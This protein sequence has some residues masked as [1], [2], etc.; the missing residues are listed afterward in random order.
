MK[1]YSP[2]VLLSLFFFSN[3]SLVCSQEPTPEN[4][5]PSTFAP[6]YGNLFKT[7]YLDLSAIYNDLTAGAINDLLPPPVEGT[8]S[9]QDDQHLRENVFDD[10]TKKQI[11]E[12]KDS[13]D[14]IFFLFLYVRA[15]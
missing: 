14:S 2:Y 10:A 6:P 8:I 4:P 11:H 7:T 5:A 1:P 15:F 12:A 3:L 13:V 9:A